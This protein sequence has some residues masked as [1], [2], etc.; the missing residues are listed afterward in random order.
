MEM[1]KNLHPQIYKLIK[2]IGSLADKKG[3]KVFCVGGFVRDIL[4]GVKNFDVDIVLEEKGIEFAKI[5]ADKLNG[6]LVVHRRFQTATVI[7]NPSVFNNKTQPDKNIK[8]KIDIATARKEYYEYPA[9]LPKVSFSSIRQDLYRRDFSINA[10]AVCLNKGSFGRLTDFYNGQNDLKAKKIRTLHDLSFV[11]DPTRIFRAIR[12]EQRYNF[13][14]EPHTENLIK[15]AVSLDM[16][17]RTQKQ[18]LRNEIILILSEPKPIKAL[19][20]MHELH[21]LKFI[22]E[23]LKF[24]NRIFKMF[25]S[26][27]Q[28]CAWFELSFIDKRPIERWLI[29]FAAIVDGLNL[30]QLKLVCEK[31]VFRKCD[32]KRIMLCKKEFNNIAGVLRYKRHIPSS[33]VFKYLEGLPYEVILFIM[34]KTAS[35]AVKE[36]ISCFLREHNGV[37]LSITG[38]DLSALGISQGPRYKKLLDYILAQ[39]IDGKI[40]TKEDELELARRSL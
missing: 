20:R 7:F 16:L 17:G 6:A 25:D 23:K 26:I 3:V 30:Q 13:T 33:A 31:F 29:Y 15:K 8:F 36:R 11:E 9:A 39:K 14:I 18:R 27:E 21:K 40:R 37:N 12:F 34:A 4:L 1:K 38:K 24:N 19:V 35:Q 22:H 10:M 2:L 5:L 32:E 28:S